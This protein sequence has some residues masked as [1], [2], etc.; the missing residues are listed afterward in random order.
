MNTRILNNL[1][2]SAK[3]Q[4]RLGLILSCQISFLVIKRTP[5]NNG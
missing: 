4:F 5:L 3:A 1:G 2:C